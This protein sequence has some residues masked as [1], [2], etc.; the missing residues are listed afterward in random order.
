MAT[1]TAAA[2]RL[3][4]KIVQRRESQT[5]IRMLIEHDPGYCPGQSDVDGLYDFTFRNMDGFS[6]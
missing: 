1:T 2:K 6:E 5:M 4:N 3:R